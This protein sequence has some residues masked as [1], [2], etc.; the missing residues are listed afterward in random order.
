[1]K[2]S[3]FFVTSLSILMTSLSYL[4]TSPFI[5]STSP[6]IKS[7]QSNNTVIIQCKHR[8]MYNLSALNPSTCDVSQL[9]LFERVSYSFSSCYIIVVV[10]ISA[11]LFL[12]N[13]LLSC[14]L[15]SVPICSDYCYSLHGMNLLHQIL[16]FSVLLLRI[17]LECMLI[18]RMMST[19]FSS[20]TP[21]R[22]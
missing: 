12:F 3:Y 10:N 11:T 13:H 2:C 17:L 21:Y 4:M 9:Y 1:V 6:D 14:F 16:I 15:R 8:T 5:L 18:T 19:F 20:G 22:I 7:H